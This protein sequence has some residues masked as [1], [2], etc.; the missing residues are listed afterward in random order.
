MAEARNLYNELF[1]NVAAQIP[2]HASLADRKFAIV[3]VFW[4]SKEV[5]GQRVDTVGRCCRD[6][7]AAPT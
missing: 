4:P 3:G 7:A 5:R 6:W 1:A 2:K